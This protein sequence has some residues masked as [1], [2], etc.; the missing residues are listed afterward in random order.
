MRES[1]ST[2]EL[3]YLQALDAVAREGSFSRAAESLGYTQS[4]I[5]QQVARLER[6]A[7]QRLVERPGGPRAVSLTAA[8]QVLRRHSAAIVARIASAAADLDALASGTAG[9]LRVGCFQSIGV[10]VLPGVLREFSRAWPQ[11]RVELTE[12][13]D[14]GELL[15]AVERGELDLAFVVFPIPAGPFEA[16]ELLDDPYVLVVAADSE[17]ARRPGPVPPAALDDLPLITYAQMREVHAIENRLGRPSLTDQIVFRSNYHGTILGLAAQGV[18]AA[19]VSWLSVQPDREGIQVLGLDRVR[20][21]TVGIAW[22]QDR[23]RNPAAEAF[24]RFACDAAVGEQA[25]IERTCPAA[26]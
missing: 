12:N 23:Y 16:V 17:L 1:W 6:I 7:G 4:A 15:R 19:V 25:L 11:V 8:G 24:I 18:G 2:L 20:P 10:R 3:R 14:D 22:H 9:V 21:R 5:S 26:D 13:E